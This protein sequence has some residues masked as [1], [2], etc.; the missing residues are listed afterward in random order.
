MYGACKSVGGAIGDKVSEKVNKGKKE[1]IGD[2][3]KLNK[4]GL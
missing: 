4:G 2:G 1:K 3:K